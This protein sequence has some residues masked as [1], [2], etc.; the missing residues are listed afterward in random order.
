MLRDLDIRV[1]VNTVSA[2]A[3]ADANL[4][5]ATD[6]AI[7]STDA[8]TA[9]AALV[10]LTAA[11]GFYVNLEGSG[12]ALVGEKVLTDAQ[13]Y[14]KQVFFA[15]YIPNAT[16]SGAACQASAGTSRFYLFS[17]VDGRPTQD[18][19]GSGDEV[20]LTIPDRYHELEQSGLPPTPALLFPN[21][22]STALTDRAVVCIGPECLDPGL[23]V[24]VEKTYW[25]K[26]Q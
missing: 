20:N 1:G 22:S 7:A 2:T 3:I 19:D 21:V 12:H 24:S 23:A 14:N 5:D 17:V 10:D 16:I 26:K 9:A 15:T 6:N 13:T 25:I 4:F 8:V 18:L 11:K